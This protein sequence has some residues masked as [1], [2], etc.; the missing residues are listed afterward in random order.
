MVVVGGGR[1]WWVVAGGGRALET[2]GGHRGQFP[3]TD[4]GPEAGIYSSSNTV[5]TPKAT[6]V[7]GITMYMQFGRKSDY[8]SYPSRIKVPDDIFNDAGLEFV[9]ERSLNL[10]FLW[11]SLTVRATVF[12]P[13][14]WIS[15]F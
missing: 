9:P 13:H 8:W 1:W 5:R 15:S 14:C 6:L 11:V 4:F 3:R 2:A 7:W 10:I 12:V